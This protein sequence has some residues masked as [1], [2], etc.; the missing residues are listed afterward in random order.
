MFFFLHLGVCFFFLHLGVCFFFFISEYVFFF[1]ISE[2]VFFFI[3]EHVF[4][5]ISE[6]VCS[7]GITRVCGAVCVPYLELSVITKLRWVLY[8]QIQGAMHQAEMGFILSNSGCHA[9][10]WDGFYILKFRGPFTTHFSKHFFSVFSS[11]FFTKITAKINKIKTFHELLGNIKKFMIIKS[12][13][14]F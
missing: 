13:N 14:N 12:K 1:F 4:F 8:Y 11:L 7:L 5:F 3:S 10:S 2:Y 9:L 6:Y